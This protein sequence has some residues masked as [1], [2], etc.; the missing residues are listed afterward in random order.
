[1]RSCKFQLACSSLLC[2]AAL[3]VV[4]Q[5]AIGSS[6]MIH[7]DGGNAF[8]KIFSGIKDTIAPGVFGRFASVLVLHPLDTVKIRSQVV[9]TASRRTA[10]TAVYRSPAVYGGILPA[11][12]GQVPHGILTCFG[13]EIWKEFLLEKVPDMDRRLRSCVC[14]VLGDLTGHLWLT[15]ME[16][17]KTQLQVGMHR[18]FG[19]AV[20]TTS[21]KGFSAFY[22]GYSGQV[23]SAVPY[24]V[25]QLVLYEE[26]CR[27][28][29]AQKQARLS[30]EESVATGAFAGCAAAVIT[31]PLDMLKS[32]MMVQN[33]GQSLPSMFSAAIRK[34]GVGVFTSSMVPQLLRVSCTTAAFLAVLSTTHKRVGPPK[35]RKSAPCMAQEIRI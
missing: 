12:A 28:F 32:R 35:I 30:L 31:T 34:E 10:E 4:P 11:I 7:T 1:M 21:Q 6:T 22:K 18:S 27:F 23:A 25:L 13:Y 19:D 9:S 14:A 8:Q 20:S 29:A 33:G 24:R 15:P 26:F 17:L 5:G 16:V 3:G 2:I